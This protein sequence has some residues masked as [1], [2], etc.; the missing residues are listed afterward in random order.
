MLVNK[1]RYQ[2]EVLTAVVVVVAVGVKVAAPTA[3][4]E[5]APVVVA[6]AIFA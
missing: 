4:A 6:P 2:L 1:A 5:M 3:T